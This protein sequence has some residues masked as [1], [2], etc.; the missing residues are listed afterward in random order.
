MWGTTREVRKN[1]YAMFSYGYLHMHTTVLADQQ[2]LK[3]ISSEWTLYVV[4]RIA[5]DQWG[6]M[7]RESQ[8]NPCYWPN[9]M[10]MMIMMIYIFTNPSAWVG[11]DTRSIFKRIL[12]GLS[13]EFSF[14]Q[15]NCPTKAEEP[16]L[17]NYLPIAGERI[18]GFIHFP[19]VLVLCEMQSVLSRI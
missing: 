16:S 6:W 11:Y 12:T 13:S 18:I 1:L 7:S 9:S 17:P 3:F 10:V 4:K 5:Q 14:S 19:M 15:T 2:R 8:G